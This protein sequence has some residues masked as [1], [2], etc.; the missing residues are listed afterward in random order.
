M[1]RTSY[2]TFEDNTTE[3]RSQQSTS[4]SI[5]S[6]FVKDNLEDN[7]K[8]EEANRNGKFNFLCNPNSSCHKAIALIL[9]CIMGFGNYFCY[10]NPGALQA[11]IQNTM[12]VS[13]YEFEK[14][15]SFYSWPNVA[16]PIIGGFLMDRVFGL[17]LGA[18][19]FAL[20]IC[21][22]QAVLAGG[23]FINSFILMKVGRAIFGIGGESIAVA[24][25]TY[26]SAWF[27][28]KILSTVIAFQLSFARVGSYANF[29]SVGPIFRSLSK[30]KR[31]Y[32]NRCA[33]MD[34]GY[35]GNLHR[36]IIDSC[37]GTRS[38]GK[39]KS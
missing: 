35:I 24:A 27:Q 11:P 1:A 30:K 9:M 32:R 23:A 15:Y 7:A 8:D 6:H 34:I 38:S 16:L 13:V 25:N 3:S 2:A 17:P 20:F 19:I 29:L 14:L 18:V 37:N 33:G 26:A 5:P 28:G 10:D 36:S 12:N 22:G 21:L 31:R 39:K 4:L